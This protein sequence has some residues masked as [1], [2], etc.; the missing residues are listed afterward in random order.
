MWQGL[1]QG[2]VRSFERSSALHIAEKEAEKTEAIDACELQLAELRRKRQEMLAQPGPL[3]IPSCRWAPS[4]L[5]VMRSKLADDEYQLPMVA[6]RIE[7]AEQAPEGL[8]A[9]ML[10]EIQQVPVYRRAPMHDKPQWLMR[11]VR[12]RDE[13]EGVAIGFVTD[14]DQE[15]FYAFLFGRQ[16]DWHSEWCKLTEQEPFFEPGHVTSENW[17]DHW[18]STRDRV[19]E[20]D[21]SCSSVS[22]E[23]LPKVPVH[24]MVVLSGLEYL[25]K[26]II[27]TDDKAIDMS[28]F[29]FELPKKKETEAQATSAARRAGARAPRPKWLT[30]LIAKYP[31]L[32]GVLAD[33]E[34]EGKDGAEV[35]ETAGASSSKRQKV[36]PEELTEEQL[37]KVWDQ[38]AKVREVVAADMEDLPCYDFHATALGGKWLHEKE[39]RAFDCISATAKDGSIAQQFL[40][41]YFPSKSARFDVPFYTL[42][43][44]RCLASTWCLKMQHY[45]DIYDSAGNENYKFSEWDHQSFDEPP[46]FQELFDVLGGRQLA[47]ATQLR[48]LR[49]K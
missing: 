49:P 36:L 45:F 16:D 28:R 27:G 22:W 39:G 5:A 41:K 33:E 20:F 17:G 43:Q 48:K 14:D 37:E 12:S 19:F 32:E 1:S 7:L 40:V 3:V 13:C 2:Q 29:L 30:G 8:P 11:M 18:L 24:R 35:G 38:L 26:N 34:A 42:G 23:E 47:R 21:T 25:S 4:D 31:W 46:D 9:E 10:E 44:A 6:L 15:L